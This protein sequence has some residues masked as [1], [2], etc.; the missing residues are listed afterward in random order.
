[1]KKSIIFKI[2]ISG[3]CLNLHHYKNINRAKRELNKLKK[4]DENYDYPFNNKYS[5]IKVTSEEVYHD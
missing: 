2:A 3:C 5:I 1:M 4:I